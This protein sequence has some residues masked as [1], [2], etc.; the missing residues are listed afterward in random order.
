MRLA[1]IGRSND[2]L[3]LHS[4]EY[5]RKMGHEA[6][7]IELGGMSNG[8]PVVFDGESWICGAHQ[9]ETFDAF[10]VRSYPGKVAMLD[11]DQNASLTVA[12]AWQRT[13]MQRDRH[14][15]A[16]GCLM[17][18]ERLGKPFCNPPFASSHFDG[19]PLQLATLQS[20][21]IRLPRT[22]VTN[23]ATAVR[24]F[25]DDVCADG[26]EVILKPTGGGAETQKVTDEVLSHLD[27]S[28][29]STPVIF[30]E[31]IKGADIRATVV[32]DKIISCV[33]ID[34]H[35]L[36]YRLGEAYRAGEQ[37]YVAH[38]LPTE[39]AAAC[40]KVARLNELVLAGIDLKQNSHGE[41]FFLEA[42]SAPVYLDI[43]RKTGAPITEAIIAWLA[44]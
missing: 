5:A 26:G 30:Q 23:F 39:V 10:L 29:S 37:H 4:L 15:F 31:R 24:A 1:V 16:L 33:S 12:D 17:A 7:L 9:L 34:S 3:S 13:M 18:L 25:Y 43:E 27:V 38:T 42:N 8:V 6:E 22:M 21:G 28:L 36:D 35:D 19:K 14:D 41:Y 44:R 40:L 20:A 32:G 2:I 11:I